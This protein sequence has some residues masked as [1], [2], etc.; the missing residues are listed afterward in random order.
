MVIAVASGKGGTGK[1]TVSVA[2]AEALSARLL[3]AD[4]EEPNAHLFLHPEIAEETPVY[5]MVPSVDEKRCTFCGECKKIC[6]FNA[7]TVFPGT[8]L[9][10]PELCH[11]CYGCLEVCPE[12]C[13]TEAQLPLGRILAGKAQEVFLAYGELKLGEAM[14]SPLIKELKARYLVPQGLNILD[15]PPGA[16]CPVLTAVHGSDFCLLVTEPT[17][18]GLHD[19]KQAVCAF[20]SMNLP[21]GV[22]VN[23]AR[24]PYGPLNDFLRSKN[25]PILLEIPE[26]RAIAEAYARGKTLIQ[27]KPEMR[28]VFKN[29]YT[30]IEALL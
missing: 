20:E 25:I 17:P 16:A 29:L 12:N 21:M 30:R 14:A 19:L 4:V 27:A 10:F 28:E 24:E 2:L 7:I 5:R 6:R 8:V 22:V 18:F 26:E 15:C 23:R 3:D 13:I 1:T 11:G 9:V